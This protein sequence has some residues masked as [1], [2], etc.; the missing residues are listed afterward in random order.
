MAEILLASTTQN[1]RTKESTLFIWVLHV[2]LNVSILAVVEWAMVVNMFLSVSFIEKCCV[3][4]KWI[5]PVD[6]LCVNA[7]VNSMLLK[8]RMANTSLRAVG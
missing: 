8:F 2:E 5:S 7:A 3:Y 1:T 6:G 4:P